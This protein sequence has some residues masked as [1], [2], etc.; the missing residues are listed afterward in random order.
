MIAKQRISQASNV[1]ERL[2]QPPQKK[3]ERNRDQVEFEKQAQECTFKP[4]TNL[5]MIKQTPS[6]K[7]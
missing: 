6:R 7:L 1:S 5:N 2:Y 4:T 3:P